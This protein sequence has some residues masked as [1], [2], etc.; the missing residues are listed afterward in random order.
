MDIKQFIT[1]ATLCKVKNFTKT[2]EILGY[3]QS[4]ITAQIQQLENELGV[5]LFERIG[6]NITLTQE[7]SALIPYVT[8]VI[9]LSTEMKNV[10]S[11]ADNGHG[12]ITIGAAESLCCYRL[13]SII[14]AY[15]I[16][17]PNVDIYLKLAD[18]INFLPLLSDNTIDIAFTIGD[19]IVNDSVTTVME[20]PEPINILAYP[21]HPLST[22]ANI[23]ARDFNDQSFIF[24]SPGCCYRAAFERD[25]KNHHSIPKVVLE[26][27]SIQAIKQTAM[28]GLGLCVLPEIAVQEELKNKKLTVL[29]YE[30]NYNIVSQLIH[31]KDKW[32]SPLLADFIKEARLLMSAGNELSD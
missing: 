22:F 29:N 2:A 8:K 26:A 10:I 14:K 15:K 30:H 25:L 17:H 6:K 28:N 5:R 23:S 31:H 9:T 11:S 16:K 21:E 32:I 18:G 12:C 3:A 13:P 27:S 7:G 4:S 20:I 1:F 19:R 24:T